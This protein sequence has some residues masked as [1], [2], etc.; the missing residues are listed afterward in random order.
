MVEFINH[1]DRRSHTCFNLGIADVGQKLF[2]QS[3][4]GGPGCDRQLLVDARSSTNFRD[5][6][7]ISVNDGHVK[8][9]HGP[10][11]TQFQLVRKRT[12]GP[13]FSDSRGTDYK[14][15]GRAAPKPLRQCVDET[16][17][18][19]RLKPNALWL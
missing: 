1:Q 14:A 2:G 8:D 13:A 16:L 6:F 4:G 5:G 9:G 11:V 15:P 19:G 12:R 10:T 17:E 3:I 18:G 7:G